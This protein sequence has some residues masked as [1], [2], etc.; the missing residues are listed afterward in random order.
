MPI[1]FVWYRIALSCPHRV[2]P[3]QFPTIHLCCHGNA[4]PFTCAAMAMPDP[5]PVLP[6]VLACSLLRI[7]VL[8]NCPIGQCH[9]PLLHSM[10]KANGAYIVPPAPS[11]A[12]TTGTAGIACSACTPSTT[13]TGH[14]SIAMVREG[15]SSN[16]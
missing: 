14:P 12:C 4:R 8:P 1:M 3:W 13:T 9:V 5:S 11:T 7:A 16:R 6:R 10:G 15:G 2:L